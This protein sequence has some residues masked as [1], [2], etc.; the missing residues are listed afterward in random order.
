MKLF[1]K[2]IVMSVVLSLFSTSLVHGQEIVEGKFGTQYDYDATNKLRTMTLYQYGKKLMQ[3]FFYDTNG[4]LIAKKIEWYR[5]TFDQGKFEETRYTAGYPAN[6]GE[7]SNSTSAVISGS[8]SVIGTAPG[9]QEWTEFLHTDRNKM[10][11]EPNTTY[12]IAFK[13]K[14]NQL[15]N[16]NGYFYFLAKSPDGANGIYNRGFT[17]W[18]GQ[19]GEIG[20]KTFTLTTGDSENYYLIWGLNRGGS[21][22]IDDIEITKIQESFESGSYT[23]IPYTKGYPQNSG[24]ITTIPAKVISGTYSILGEAASSQEWT[25]FLHSDFKKM[26]FEPN[27]TYTVAFKYKVNQLPGQNGSF[28]FLARSPDGTN[29]T[30]DRGFTAWNGQVGEIGTKTI[31][32]TTGSS[33]NY[34][35]IWGLNNGGSLSI[36]DIEI[37]KVQ[38]SFESGGYIVAPYNRGYPHNS[39][40]ITSDPSKV[41][42]GKYSILGDAASS[43]EWTEFLHSDLNKVKLEPNKTYKVS[44]KYKVN[45]LSDQNG[46]FYFLVKSIDWANSIN[47]KGFTTWTGQIGEIGTKTVTFTTGDSYNYYLIWGLNYGG[48]LSIDDVKIES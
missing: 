18:T 19:V 8:H 9:T 30:F 43:Q 11:F 20:T 31:T 17:T 36:D 44:F 47:S 32:F 33:Q 45:R 6:A 46:Y 40:I 24:N 14:V 1:T 26:K 2:L 5:D 21:L 23:E 10:K 48:S 16:Q 4:N 37:T 13:Y 28:Y 39:G 42:S 41:I 27:T 35:V 7:I 3:N 34:Y 29:S 22:S 15:S 38:E 12:K 25:E